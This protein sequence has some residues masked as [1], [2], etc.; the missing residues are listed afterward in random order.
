MLITDK[1]AKVRQHF[2]N[3]LG[4]IMCYLPDRYDYL[5]YMSPYIL[6]GLIDEIP[7]IQEDAYNWILKL[8][9]LYEEDNS[10][11]ILEKKQYGVDGVITHNHN[12]NILQYPPPFKGRPSIGS[13]YF[14]R[15]YAKRFVTPLL[16]EIQSWK[17]DIQIRSVKLLMVMIIFCEENITQ[18]IN[19][20]ISVLYNNIL[21][22][23][24]VI[25]IPSLYESV[26]TICHIIGFFT[27]P[28]SY[29]KLLLPY[30]NSDE[31]LLL[32]G[33]IRYLYLIIL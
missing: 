9:K 31:R 29:V 10:E 25:K 20:V 28:S 24:K 19:N 11:S 27:S 16:S 7:S 15:E 5:P 6:S 22:R 32:S 14:V 33:N 4:N 12:K 18:E 26:L 17:E 1:N 21:F 30:I 13:R 23:N 3:I 8:G 2:I